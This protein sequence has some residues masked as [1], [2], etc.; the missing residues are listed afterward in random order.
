MSS[1]RPRG[2]FGEQSIGGE[3]YE[4]RSV[5]QNETTA[6]AVVDP[7]VVVY[8]T[9]IPSETSSCPRGS[10]E[11]SIDGEPLYRSMR[12]WRVASA[13]AYFVWAVMVGYWSWLG[14]APMTTMVVTVVGLAV[15]RHVAER[16][17]IARKV[18][19][20]LRYRALVYNALY[21]THGSVAAEALFARVVHRVFPSDRKK[22]QQ[23]K[24]KVW[25]HIVRDAARDDRIHIEQV[26][27]KAIW[28]WVDGAPPA[29]FV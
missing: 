7:V 9:V 24:A 14:Q 6:L 13:M 17:K 19:Y 18:R 8:D 29:T 5:P 20:V 23:L 27:G 3:Q 4:W 15:R 12:W 28:E 10:D 11:P 22:R 21:E 26:Q 2:G 1:F 25:K 16:W